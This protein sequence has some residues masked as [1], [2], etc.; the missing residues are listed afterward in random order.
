LF[1][2]RKTIDAK[3]IN[4]DAIEIH[5]LLFLYQLK[6]QK[7]HR[8]IE[9]TQGNC[10]IISFIS[11]ILRETHARGLDRRGLKK[12]FFVKFRFFAEFSGR[13]LSRS[14]AYRR[15]KRYFSKASASMC[16]LAVLF[17]LVQSVTGLIAG[18]GNVAR[19][20]RGGNPKH[21]F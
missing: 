4:V 10:S 11:H 18:S 1:S 6:A 20:L 7:R 21:L 19:R 13:F 14:I 12:S 17:A 5:T 16:P 2:K 3:N 9:P 15:R 8:T